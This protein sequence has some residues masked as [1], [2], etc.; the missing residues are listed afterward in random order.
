MAGK[1]HSRALSYAHG[2]LDTAP[3]RGQHARFRNG[4]VLAPRAEKHSD[5]IVGVYYSGLQLGGFARSLDNSEGQQAAT[6]F[7]ISYI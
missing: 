1:Q 6:A 3:R 2:T 4:K 5:L 7:L